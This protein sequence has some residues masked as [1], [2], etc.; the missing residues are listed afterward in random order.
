MNIREQMEQQEM[1]Q[2]HSLSFSVKTFST[3]W[4]EPVT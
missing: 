4:A 2:Q 1:K 3:A